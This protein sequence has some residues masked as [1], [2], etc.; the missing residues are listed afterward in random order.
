MDEKRRE[1]AFSTKTGRLKNEVVECKDDNAGQ[2]NYG[3]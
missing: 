2:I 3:E 1:G